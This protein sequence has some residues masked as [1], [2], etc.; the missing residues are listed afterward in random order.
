MGS[1]FGEAAG[2]G[3]NEGSQIMLGGCNND[4]IAVVA[5]DRFTGSE[6]IRVTCFGTGFFQ[7]YQASGTAFVFVGVTYAFKNI[8]AFIALCIADIV[9]LMFCPT[10]IA[11]DIAGWIADIV[12]FVIGFGAS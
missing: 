2:G 3:K 10:R 12:V 6:A 11:A 7:T 5:I 9:I 4:S 1:A 8:T